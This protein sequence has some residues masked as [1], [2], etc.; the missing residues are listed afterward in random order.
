MNKEQLAEISK[1][2]RVDIVKMINKA[3]SGHPGGSLSVI[4]I[5]T[6]LYF[7]KMNVD[8]QNPKDEN[9][10]RF[11]LS[12]GHAAPALYATLAKKGFFPKEELDNLRVLGSILQGHPDSKKCPGIDICTGSLGQ[13]F[14]NACGI[15]IGNKLNKSDAKVYVA[16]GDG[17]IQEGIVWEAMMSAAKYKLDNLVAII[18]F[19]GI[20]LDG[21][22][23][24]IMPIDNLAGRVANF[25][26]NVVECDGHNFDEIHEAFNKADE[27]K[28]KPT[29]IIAHTIKGKGVSFME[30]NVAW[31]GAAPNREQTDEAIKELIG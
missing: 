23:N 15:A 26:W 3:G 24:E 31:H 28:D 29:C 30:D 7:E 14:S 1:E 19:N 21:R 13:G 16:L 25:G 10:D 20:Q 18:D 27:C 8:V 17:E 11:V 12:K 2:L 4:D 5:L 22:T 9:R 6:Y